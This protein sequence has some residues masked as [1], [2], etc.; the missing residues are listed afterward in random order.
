MHRRIV[1]K[2]VKPSERKWKAARLYA[3]VFVVCAVRRSPSVRLR[4][5]ENVGAQR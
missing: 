2:R 5:R 4:G 1:D 3:K